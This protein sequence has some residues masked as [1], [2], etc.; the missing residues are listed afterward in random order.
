MPEEVEKEE[1]WQAEC[2]CDTLMKAEEI[3]AD[4][5][6]LKAAMMV[7][8]DRHEAMK[9]MMSGTRPMSKKGIE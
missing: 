3:K 7:A 5:S 9:K 6:R 8:T 2:D 1:K 4:K